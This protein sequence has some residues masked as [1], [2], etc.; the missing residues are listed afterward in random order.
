[1]ESVTTRV[2]ALNHLPEYQRLLDNTQHTHGMKSGR[3]YLGPGQS[4]GQHSTEARE[5]LLVFLSG[6]GRLEIQNEDERSVGSGYIAYIPPHT[7]HN[8]I[9]D[10]PEPL[11]YIFCVA[12][13]QGTA[14]G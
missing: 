7:L 1:V 2:I 9:N 12:P 14:T 6:H 13:V 5:E 3:V 8:V 10:Q 4:C 11:V